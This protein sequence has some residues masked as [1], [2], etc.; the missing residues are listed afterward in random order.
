MIPELETLLQILDLK[1]QR[2]ELT[3]G[4]GARQVQEEEFHLDVDRA[5]DEL[6]AKIDELE[7]ELPAA[8]RSRYRRLASHQ[9]RVVVPAINGVCYGCFVSVPIAIASDPAEQA[10]LQACDHCGRFLYFVH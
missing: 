4:G 1:G 9:S 8:I 3:E 7:N 5:I 10:R 6:Q 2:R